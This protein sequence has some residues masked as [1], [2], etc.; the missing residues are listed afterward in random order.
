MTKNV[1]PDHGPESDVLRAAASV[2]PVFYRQVL[3]PSLSL[4][5]DNGPVSLPTGSPS[6]VHQSKLEFVSE[7]VSEDSEPNLILSY[8]YVYLTTKIAW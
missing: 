5:V 7:W 6:G 4:A 3:S 1:S 8:E 2:P